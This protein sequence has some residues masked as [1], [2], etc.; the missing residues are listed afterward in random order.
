MYKIKVNQKHDFEVDRKAEELTVNGS[1]I[2]ADIKQLN[3]K[4]YHI[5]NNNG[6]YNAEVVS[7]DHEAKTAEIKVNNNIYTLAAKDQF[8]V[9]LDKMGLS[10]L[11]AAKVSD[12][13][14]PMPGMV[15][16]V[17]VEEGAKIKKGD[18]LFVLEAMKMENIIKA[19]ADVIIKN[20]K[21]KPGDKVEKGQILIIF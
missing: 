21:I 20:I 15:L 12:I 13:K 1:N 19:P 11:M 14:A 3:D 8:D 4:L 2:Q 6:S 7:F 10:N 17:L 5:I 9:L 18:N 16:K